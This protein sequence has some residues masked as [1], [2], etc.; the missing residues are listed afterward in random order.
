MSPALSKYAA[1]KLAQAEAAVETVE[2]I[3]VPVEHEEGDFADLGRLPEL[4]ASHLRAAQE[5][6]KKATSVAMEM[7]RL[8]APGIQKQEP[9]G[10]RGACVAMSK[11]LKVLAKRAAKVV[12][13]NEEEKE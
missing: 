13:G 9:I 1:K 8:A 12:N 5:A 6:L 7:E 2:L 4:C 11:R 3:A 10:I